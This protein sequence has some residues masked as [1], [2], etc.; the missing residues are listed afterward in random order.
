MMMTTTPDPAWTYEEYY[1]PAIFGPLTEVLLGHASPAAG[2]RVLDVACGTGIVARRIAPLVGPEGDVQGVDR[3]PAMLEVARACAPPAP[4]I[5][6][7]VGDAAALEAADGTR[8]RI[9]CQQGLQFLPDRAAGVA[10]MRRVLVDGGVAVVAVWEGLDR[11]PLYAALFEAELPALGRFGVPADEAELTAPFS[12]GDADEL[13]SLFT[14][15]GFD[16]VHLVGGSIQ[17]RFAEADRFIERMQLAYAA[18]M[19]G[20]VEDTD[21][22][23]A[24]VDEVTRRTRPVVEAHREGDHV[25]VPMHTNLVIAS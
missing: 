10:E 5:D 18:V 2:E 17:A 6:W 13:G 24:Y 14:D 8:D 20:F 15:A 12:F 23:A 7:Q 19:P 9:T 1:I 25:V 4:A 16:D 3:S 22:F 21:A 11:H